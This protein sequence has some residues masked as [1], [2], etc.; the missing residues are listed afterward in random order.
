M[1][2][3]KKQMMDIQKVKSLSVA[4]SDEHQRNWGDDLFSRKENDPKYNYDRSRTRLNFQVSKGGELGPVDKSKSITEKIEQAIKN[5]VT[6]RVNATSNRAVSLVFGGNREQMRKLAFGDQPISEN[7][8]NWDVD[9][10][11]GIDRWAKDIYDFCCREFGEENVV[12]FIVHLD[13]LNPHAHAVIVPITK[14]GRL[15]AKDMFGGNDMN[16]ARTRMRELH[17]RLAEVNEKYGLERG[18]DITITG[19]KHKSTETYRRELADECRT[20]SNEVGMKKTLLSGLN[21]S[22]TKAE[23]KIKALQ[24]M[25]SNLEKVEADKQTT[26]AELEDYMKNHLGDAVEIKAKITATRKELWDVRDKL[27]DKK[28]KLEQ[29]KL[30]L[31][32]LQKNTS[33][34]E[35]RNRDI[36]ADFEKTVVS[37]QQQ[38]I[39]KI[40]AQA[41]MKALSEIANIYPRMTSIH[42]SSLFDD[43]FAMDFINYGD[44]IIYCAMY[45]YVGYVNEA[46]NFAESQGGGGSDAKDWGR[47][48]DED[49]IEWIRR[50][51]RQATRMVKPRK[52]KG[53]SR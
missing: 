4:V 13:E 49:E 22:I 50:C 2:D 48:K 45:L 5:R 20:L 47:E 1:S 12:S 15:S 25:V 37:Y 29:A 10:C 31:N 28:M 33:H 24:T 9:S 3:N 46:T 23:T 27:N 51:L 52:G 35:A 30:L 6:G 34:I 16:Q 32:E 21:R 8:N 42:D 40:W 43:S 39:N 11:S 53:L 38:M 36:K 17:S 26:I 18:D 19:A 7:G 44:K 41:G 14:D